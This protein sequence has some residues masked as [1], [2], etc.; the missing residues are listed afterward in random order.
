MSNKFLTE[1]EINV[2]ERGLSF[3]PTP[4][5]LHEEDL[6]RDFDDFRRKMRCR[7]YFRNEPSD[8]FNEVPAFKLKSLWKPP[9]GHPC[10]NLILS[11]L[12]ENFFSFLPG[13][14]ETYNLCNK[15]L[16]TMLNLAGGCSIIIE[17]ANKSFCV[18]IWECEDYLAEGYK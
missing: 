6:R 9:A 14:P 2:L 8:N 12:E 1:T 3:V 7:W 15:E 17:P 5:L 10:V 4:N 11:R 16:Q 13:I 18:V